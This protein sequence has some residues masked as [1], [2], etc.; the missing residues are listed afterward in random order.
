MGGMKKNGLVFRLG[1]ALVFSPLLGLKAWGQGANT[2]GGQV[3]VNT[4]PTVTAP[5]AVAAPD[6]KLE[7]LKKQRVVD[8]KRVLARGARLAARK[9]RNEKYLKDLDLDAK[10]RWKDEKAMR[11]TG[12]KLSKEEA[13]EVSKP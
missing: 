10:K 2:S 13:E 1:L 3:A 8:E 6:P 12:K 9:S 5:K 7:A 11:S 4:T